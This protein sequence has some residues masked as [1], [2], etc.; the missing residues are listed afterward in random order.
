MY[1]SSRDPG[2][3]HCA[4]CHKAAVDERTAPGASIVYSSAAIAMNRAIHCAR[5]EPFMIDPDQP[6]RIADDDQYCV[7]ISRTIR[8]F[9]Y[10]IRLFPSDGAGG[11]LEGRVI[12]M[13]SNSNPRFTTPGAAI[14]NSIVQL[15]VMHG[16]QPGSSVNEIAAQLDVVRSDGQVCPIKTLSIPASPG[17]AIFECFAVQFR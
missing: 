9:Q 2:G 16:D 5:G 14:R 11:F 12:A 1:F 15:C 13:G 3:G 4:F 10:I 8:S 17:S 7:T 6:I